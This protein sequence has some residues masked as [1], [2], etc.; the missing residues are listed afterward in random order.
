MLPFIVSRHTRSTLE[1]D[2]FVGFLVNATIDNKMYELRSFV[3]IVPYRTIAADGSM[4]VI[5]ALL[6]AAVL[7][8]WFC[9]AAIFTAI[10]MGMRLALTGGRRS[11]GSAGMATLYF[12][13]LARVLGNSVGADEC[14]WRSESL[15]MFVMGVF[16]VTTSM[17]LTGILFDQMV[18]AE[19]PRQIDTMAELAASNLSIV[20][21]SGDTNLKIW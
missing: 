16:A 14:S 19:A 3:A 20:L 18:A 21:C 8:V 11:G 10:R 15:V 5:N 7:L 9:G 2:F 6:N 1:N 12:R 17:V 4:V 13:C